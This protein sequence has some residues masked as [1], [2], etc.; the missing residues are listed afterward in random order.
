M[1]RDI[2][3]DMRPLVS[4]QLYCAEAWWT[5]P[6][7]ACTSFHCREQHGKGFVRQQ[8]VRRKGKTPCEGKP[9]RELYSKDFDL[10]PCLTQVG[11]NRTGTAWPTST[12]L[13]RSPLRAVEGGDVGL[14]ALSRLR[15]CESHRER[16]VACLGL[17]NTK[18][19]AWSV[20]VADLTDNLAL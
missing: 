11:T 9:I 3:V 7:E 13:A 6:L 16:Q 2:V 19:L 4:K 1:W 5:D 18:P 10:K 8:N 12:R 20:G 14:S 17:R 15:E